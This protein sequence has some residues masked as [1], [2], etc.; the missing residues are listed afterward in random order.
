MLLI[1]PSMSNYFGKNSVHF[2]GSLIW[3]SRANFD[4]CSRSVFEFKN[5][6]KQFGNIECGCLIYR[7]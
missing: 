4:K 1:P 5:N 2:H 7:R 3:N 6:L